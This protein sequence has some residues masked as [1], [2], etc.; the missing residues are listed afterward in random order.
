[1]GKEQFDPPTS[2]A[3]KQVEILMECESERIGNIAAL[4]EVLGAFIF[5][6]NF[7]A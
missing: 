3:G 2:R 4:V 6:R 5:Q 7:A 1:M